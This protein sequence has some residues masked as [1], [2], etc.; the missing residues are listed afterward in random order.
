M[1]EVAS[2]TPRVLGPAQLHR[3]A[4]AAVAARLRR[5]VLSGELPAG[6]RLLQAQLAEEMH[7]STTPVREAMRELVGE[8]LIDL[9][10]HRGVVVHE[11]NRDEFDEVYQL[12]TILEPVAIDA[13]VANI[14]AAELAEAERLADRMQQE[15]DV[16]EW[17]IL[18]SAFHALLAEA[19]R[20]PILTAI[21]Q[22]LQNL[23]TLYVATALQPHPDRIADAND[24][25]RAILD[26]CRMRDAE[27]MKKIELQHLLSSVRMGNA[28]FPP[29]GDGNR[30]A[31]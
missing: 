14:S 4:Q 31:S 12:R 24:E 21:L 7:T 6:S 22:R 2:P 11:C 9:D 30:S 18:N 23:S 15:H 8:G 27:L 25:H 1:T 26:A 20:L 10:P 19:S 16:A 3:T 28:A 13:T 17:V 29:A 5:A